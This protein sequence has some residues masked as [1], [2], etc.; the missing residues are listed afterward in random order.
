M[1]ERLSDLQ[2]IAEILVSKLGGGLVNSWVIEASVFNGPFAVYKDFI[3][4]VNQWGDPKS[5]D[6]TGFPASR[7]TV[8]LLSNFLQQ[9]LLPSL[10]FDDLYCKDKEKQ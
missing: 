4:S 2:N 8:A 6:P 1:I 7:S 9:V 3:P 10:S 5:Y